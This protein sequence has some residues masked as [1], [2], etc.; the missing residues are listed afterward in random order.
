MAAFL[1]RCPNTGLLVQG[2]SESEVAE[3]GTAFEAITSLAQS[4]HRLVHRTCL[5]LTQRGHWLVRWL[6]RLAKSLAD[7][8]KT[9]TEWRAHQTR[10]LQVTAC[11]KH[12]RG[13]YDD[14]KTCRACAE[15]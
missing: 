4:R 13:S 15:D 2:W 1:F 5:P 9:P 8:N 12:F 3:N 7:N 6:A 14:P 10:V 11:A